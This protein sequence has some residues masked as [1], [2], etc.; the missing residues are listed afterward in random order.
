MRTIFWLL[1]LS[2]TGLLGYLLHSFIEHRKTQVEFYRYDVSAEVI[3]GYAARAD[4]LRQQANSL[5]ARLERTGLLQRRAVRAHL[6]LLEDEIV[7][8]ER[9]VEKWKKSKRTRSEVD[10]GRQVILLY[11]EASAAAQALAADTLLEH[12]P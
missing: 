2:L 3:A 11:G 8:L 1:M 7:A 6:T 9:T 4:S 10:L 12:E 5:R